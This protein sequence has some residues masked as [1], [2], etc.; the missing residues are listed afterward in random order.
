MKNP[1]ANCACIGII[2]AAAALS[3]ASAR[4]EVGA[5]DLRGSAMNS[6]VLA[7][8][9]VSIDQSTKW[10]NVDYGETVQFKVTGQDGARQF[11]WRFDGISDLLNLSDIDREAGLSIPVY[12]QQTKN[13]LHDNAGGGE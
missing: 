13:P 12:V 2:A 7:D 6:G 4:A 11:V 10:V 1:I 9:T 3:A 5:D 8:R